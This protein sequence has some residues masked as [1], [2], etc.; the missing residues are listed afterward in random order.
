VKAASFLANFVAVGIF[1]SFVARQIELARFT[2]YF[3][4]VLTNEVKESP[5]QRIAARRKKTIRLGR[6]QN[7]MSPVAATTNP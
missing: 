4:K 5:R 7:K 1:V 6:R 3:E 2:E